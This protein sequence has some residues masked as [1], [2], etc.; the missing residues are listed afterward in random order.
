MGL[1]RTKVVDNNQIAA[2]TDGNFSKNQ[3]KKTEML[4]HTI[5]EKTVKKAVA[6]KKEY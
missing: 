3:E 2:I 4:L 6:Q 5:Q 1:L